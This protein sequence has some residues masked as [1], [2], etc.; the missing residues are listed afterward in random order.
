MKKKQQGFNLAELVIV[1]AIIGTLAGIA[2]PAYTQHLLETRRSDGW[3][4]LNA[5]AA[6]QQ[7]WYAVNFAYTDELANLGGAT[8]PERYYTITVV[9]DASSFTLT[10]TAKST[11]LQA[12]DTGCTVLMLTNTGQQ[13]PA[14]CW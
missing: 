14:S 7:R 1:I 11:G 3:I 4:A 5:A 2:Y 12:G 9:A 10:A 8:S 13:S 6:A